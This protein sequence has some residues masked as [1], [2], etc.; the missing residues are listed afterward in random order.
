MT[1]QP[2]LRDNRYGVAMATPAGASTPAGSLPPQGASPRAIRDALT[3]PEDRVPS[4]PV[5]DVRA[6]I[7][8]S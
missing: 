3:I 2:R 8:S 5:E 1:T 7:R 6:L 4:V